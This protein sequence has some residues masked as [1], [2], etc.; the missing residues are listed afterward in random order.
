PGGH[1]LFPQQLGEQHAV[2]EE[3]A[4]HQ[5]RRLRLTGKRLGRE[6]GEARDPGM[7][8]AGADGGRG[9]ARAHGPSRGSTKWPT[10]KLAEAARAA[11][12]EVLIAIASP[13]A[14]RWRE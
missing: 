9:T 7:P 4:R 5:D 3:V 6:S 14:Q 13:C 12:L 2:T 11:G 8:C 1:L 10:H